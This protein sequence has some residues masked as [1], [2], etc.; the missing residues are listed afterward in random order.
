MLSA[1][2]FHSRTFPIHT[3]ALT[4]STPIYS[5]Y[6]GCACV[7]PP[8]KSTA[9]RVATHS[10]TAMAPGRWSC[11]TCGLVNKATE[12]ACSGCGRKCENM[13][14]GQWSC[15]G[16]GKTCVTPTC[17]GC[18]YRKPLSKDGVPPIFAGCRI[19]FTG[20]IPRSIPHWSE[21]K[22][23]QQVEQFGG[24]PLNE[25]TPDMTHLIYKEGFERSDKVRKVQ[26][27][28]HGIKIVGSEWFYQSVNLG[29]RLDEDPYSLTLPQKRLN[30]ASVQGATSE[31]AH[32]YAE[33]LSKIA[34]SKT[35]VEAERG[36]RPRPSVALTEEGEFH[37]TVAPTEPRPLFQ[38]CTVVFSPSVPDKVCG[39]RMG[40]G[41]GECGRGGSA[42]FNTRAH[43]AEVSGSVLL[44]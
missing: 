36:E 37:W 30:A 31:I 2:L 15:N 3:H 44:R 9:G 7:F 38:D 12:D 17:P 42:L 26:K 33:Q 28:G 23:W 5:P 4:L 20:I 19:T 43:T 32:S 22:E 25:I 18:N 24:I 8:T 6:F 11:A 1:W 34:A 40:R 14:T 39:G 13:D 21:W 41:R 29:V 10:R 35:T 16:C 27:L